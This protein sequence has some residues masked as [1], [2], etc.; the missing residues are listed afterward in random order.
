MR[1]SEK[2]RDQLIQELAYARR[3]VGEPESTVRAS[4]GMESADASAG[5]VGGPRL[6]A[7][8]TCVNVG[9][10]CA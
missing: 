2:T 5:G 8:T 7:T 9:Y 3:R 4:P 6:E 10:L 1:D